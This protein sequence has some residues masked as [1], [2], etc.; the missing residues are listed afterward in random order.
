MIW[1]KHLYM[2][3][4][5]AAG[6]PAI[7]EGIRRGKRMPGVYV[8]TLPESGNHILDIRPVSLLTEKERGDGAFLILGAALGYGEACQVVRRMVDDMYR[9]T[10]AFDWRDY[11]EFLEAR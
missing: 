2:G 7:L 1:W 11:M 4:K 6:R 9:A 8:I 3:D 10:G 5:A